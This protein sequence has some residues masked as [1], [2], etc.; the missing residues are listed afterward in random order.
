MGPMGE[1]SPNCES[2]PGQEPSMY[3]RVVRERLAVIVVIV[4]LAVGLTLFYSIR[5][6][7]MY[8]ATSQVLRQTA[9]LD[10]TLFGT[11]VFQYQ[12]AQ[13]QLQT[14][15]DLIKTRAVA[16]MV[17]KELGSRRS[18]GNLLQMVTA[19]T[20]NQ[21]DI[22]RITAESPDPT[23][24]ADVANSFAR[25]FINYRQEKNRA[26]LAA[27]DEQVVSEL[28]NMNAEE[29]ASERGVTLTRKH[30]ELR[31]LLAMQTGGFEFIQEANVPSS[32]FSPRPLRNTGFALAGGLI[33]GLLLAFFLEYA[34]KR[35]KD[36][37]A[38][39]AVMGLPVLASVPMVGKKWSRRSRQRPRMLIESADT[40]SPFA[41]SFRMLRSNL[42]FF[43]RGEDT[44][45]LLITSGLPEEG[46]SV[47]SINLAVSLALSGARVILIE[48]DLRRPML[49]HYLN[50]ENDL[51][52]STVLAGASTFEE[53]LQMIPFPHGGARFGDGS[54]GTRFE[55][56]MAKGVLCLP[57]GPLPPN[58]AELLSAPRMKETLH[59]ATTLAEYVIIDTPPILLV[60]DALNL[61]D[62]VD[63]IIVAVRLKKTTHEEAR[64][65]TTILKR[66]G[67]RTLGVVAN[68]A[69][70]RRRDYYR[71]R[72][73][74]YYTDSAS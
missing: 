55:T 19:T 33:L 74:A 51:G 10:Q 66:S 35:I 13:R 28:E 64:N 41:E 24:A 6:T 20:A 31:I 8:S 63:G 21:T 43:R 57:S 69:R 15:A 45:T 27:A 36:E 7:P 73:Q 40:K 46:K 44:Q 1:T 26:V 18:V 2:R 65:I 53:S 61:A 16:E 60:S 37:E 34:D 72:H 58:P 14:G 49:R 11:S 56:T 25:Q 62:W 9:A 70:E 54:R 48:A 52:L 59:T 50:L 38:L 23:E 4:I 68:G 12:D 17:K 42:S 3:L 47:T 22:I 71:G 32:P 67:G 5:Q 29:L 30:E 39:E